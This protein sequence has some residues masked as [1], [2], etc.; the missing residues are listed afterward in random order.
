[1]LVKQCHKPPIYWNGLDYTSYKNGDLGDSKNSRFTSIF[2]GPN[3]PL[4]KKSRHFTKLQVAHNWRIH[5]W[6]YL[7]NGHRITRPDH[8]GMALQRFPD[9][10]AF[11]VPYILSHYFPIIIPYYPILSHII[12]YYP[13]LSHYYPIIIPLLSHIIL[14]PLLSHII[15]LLSHYYPILSH[16]RVPWCWRFRRW[17]AVLQAAAYVVELREVPVVIRHGLLENIMKYPISNL[18]IYISKF[19][20][21]FSQS[22]ILKYPIFHWLSHWWVIFPATFI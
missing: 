12:P 1:M 10:T 7:W 21:W 2:V 20:G 22:K 19:Y 5:G 17:P 15:P 6:R 16:C 8:N 18:Y 9:V 13:I 3:I 11:F 14:I 4:K